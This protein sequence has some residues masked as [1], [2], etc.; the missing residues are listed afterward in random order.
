MTSGFNINLDVENDTE[1]NI[2][3]FGNDKIKGR[4]PEDFVEDISDNL[5]DWLEQE[6]EDGLIG[7]QPTQ[8]VTGIT[9]SGNKLSITTA[10]IQC[11]AVNPGGSTDIDVI[12]CS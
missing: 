6:T 2:C 11:L 5:E 9:L 12:E 4:S 3:T 8:V 7:S 1:G 10:S